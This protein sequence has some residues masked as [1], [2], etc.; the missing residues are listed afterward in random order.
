MCAQ[1]RV[2][3]NRGTEPRHK[4][5]SCL[6]LCNMRIREHV[7][8]RLYVNINCFFIEK[9]I[10]GE[11]MGSN[12][13]GYAIFINGLRIKKWRSRLSRWARLFLLCL[14]LSCSCCDL[15]EG[16]LYSKAE[17]CICE[18]ARALMNDHAPH[19]TFPCLT[20]LFYKMDMKI[21]ILWFC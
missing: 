15:L 1:L 21:H 9:N 3:K 14:H 5:T 16:T 6:F 7:Y 4:C 19:L 13:T 20:L 2:F 17:A 11:C 8:M 12:S 18:W 10:T